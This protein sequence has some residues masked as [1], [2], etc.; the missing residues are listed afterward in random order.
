MK[1]IKKNEG[2]VAD[3]LA[4]RLMVSKPMVTKIIRQL[5]DASLV[6]V[7]INPEDKRNKNLFLTAK[8]SEVLDEINPVLSEVQRE[9]LDGFSDEE[10]LLFDAFM[11]RI[12]KNIE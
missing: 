11:E 3:E 5:E 12:L 6:E 8:G 4:K 2:I 7:I 10:I 1:N 9:V